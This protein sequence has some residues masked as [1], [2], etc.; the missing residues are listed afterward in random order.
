[1]KRKQYMKPLADSDIPPV[2]AL[3]RQIAERAKAEGAPAT[4]GS[5]GEQIRRDIDTR[6][7]EPADTT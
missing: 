4:P 2:V 5:W 7:F 3:G 1:M 6:Q